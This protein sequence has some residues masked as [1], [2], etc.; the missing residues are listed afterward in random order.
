MGVYERA[1]KSSTGVLELFFRNRHHYRS[2]FESNSGT[3][4]LEDLSKFARLN[5]DLFRDDPRKT[6]Y[7][8][9]QRSVVLRIVNIMNMTDKQINSLT[10]DKDSSQ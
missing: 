9:G 5:D 7:L 2:T 1:K 3:Y 8:C 6:D 10:Q 4:V